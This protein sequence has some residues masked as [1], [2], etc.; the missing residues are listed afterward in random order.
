M[1]LARRHMVLVGALG[2]LAVPGIAG[3]QAPPGLYV[4]SFAAPASIPAGERA[5]IGGRVAPAAA[6]PVV[7]ERLEDGAWT[8]IATVR[9]RGDGR[10]AARLPLRRSGNLRVSVA[11]AEGGVAS[12]R[13]RFVTVRRTVRLSVDAAPLENIAGRPFTATGVVVPSVRGERV[14]LEGSV[15]GGPFRVIARVPVRAGRVRATFTPPRGGSWRFRLSAATRPGG[16]PGGAATTGR[17]TVHGRNPHGVPATDEHH[18]VQR[19]SEMQL[20]YY[21]RGQLR[22]VFP[23]VFGKPSTPTPLGRY[24]VYSKTYGPGPAFGPR[25]LWYH[26]GYGIHGTNQEHLLTHESRYYSAGCTR[27]YNVNILW[28]WDRVPV[29]TPVVN[30][31]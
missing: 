23:V 4:S 2:A 14:A 26:R 7:V 28:L 19:I 16:G 5:E 9:S 29:G 20:Y 15:D 24:R 8:V 17:M 3:A 1:R 10:F 31:A 25:A 27:N 18:L 22:R 21:Q 13:R 11:T 12:S 6:V 30:L